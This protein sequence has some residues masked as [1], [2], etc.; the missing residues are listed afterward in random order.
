MKLNSIFC[1]LSVISLLIAQIQGKNGLC[2]THNGSRCLQCF[3][4]KVANNGCGEERSTDPCIVYNL[5]GLCKKC[6]QG[7]ALGLLTNN[8]EQFNGSSELRS[9]CA[10]AI[11]LADGTTVCIACKNGFP[12]DGGK[13]CYDFKGNTQHEKNCVQGTTFNN[14]NLCFLCKEG[15][16][17]NPWSFMCQEYPKLTGCAIYNKF[18]F[19]KCRMCHYDQGGNYNYEHK[20]DG[21]CQ[22]R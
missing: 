5:R 6:M 1:Y 2:R 4:S 11:N 14:M 9:K 20:S 21:S 10:E 17:L 7:R 13:T 16:T 18:N 19:S 15:Y 3:K 12:G 22:K 8:C